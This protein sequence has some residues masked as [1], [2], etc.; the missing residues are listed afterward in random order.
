ML[1]CLQR[2][3]VA[4]GTHFF[5]GYSMLYNQPSK[6]W[7]L[8][9]TALSEVC[10]KRT[11]T[12]SIHTRIHKQSANTLYLREEIYSFLWISGVHLYIIQV[13]PFQRKLCRN[14]VDVWADTCFRQFFSCIGNSKVLN[15][16]HPQ[17][18][19]SSS[20]HFQSTL[21]TSG[22]KRQAL[23]PSIPC[24]FFQG[25][26]LFVYLFVLHLFS[27]DFSQNGQYITKNKHAQA[28]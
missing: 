22:Y 6:V 4:P 3:A 7:L 15:P 18:F 1:E 20:L 21:P 26:C 19:K 13:L 10:S 11:L 27:K 23:L 5:R 9:F 2:E 28:I 25:F 8:F 16:Q 12:T 14:F 17:G 24:F